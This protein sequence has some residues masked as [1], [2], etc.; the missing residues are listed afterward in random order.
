MGRHGAETPYIEEHR[1][2]LLDTVRKLRK[3][4]DELTAE[5]RELRQELAVQKREVLRFERSA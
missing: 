5:N 3:R 1:D 4:C 2:A